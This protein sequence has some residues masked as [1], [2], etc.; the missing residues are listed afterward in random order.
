MSKN[1][2]LQ[3]SHE[4][5]KWL[6]SEIVEIE[7]TIK[8]IKKG[9]L[10]V[11]DEELYQADDLDYLEIRLNELYQRSAFESKNMKKLKLE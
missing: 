11:S 1:E 8:K 7:H 3:L 4:T 6:S 5:I 2:K 9:T 10:E